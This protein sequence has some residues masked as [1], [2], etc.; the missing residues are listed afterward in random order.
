[1]LR[2]YSEVDNLRSIMVHSRSRYIP[3]W[4]SQSQLISPNRFNENQDR[5]NGSRKSQRIIN[6]VATRAL[7]TFVGGMMNGSTSRQRPWFRLTVTDPRKANLSASKKYFAQLET[8]FNA[9]FQVGNL[10]KI[11]PISY[12]D[13][14]VFS[15]SAYA[16]LPHARYG[17]YFYPFAMGSYGIA[18]D[19]EGN[20]NTFFRDFTMSVRQTVERYGNLKP[21]GHI[22]WANIDPFIKEAWENAR[23]LDEVTLTNVIMPNAAPKEQSIFSYDKKFQSYTYVK[24]YGSNLPNQSPIGQ[25]QI[26]SSTSNNKSFDGRFLSVKGYDYFPVIA[27]RWELGAEDDWGIDGPGEIAYGDIATLQEME[28]DRLSGAQKLVRPPMVGPTSLRRHQASIL[29][30]GI[31]FVDENNESGKF[32][33]AFEVDPRLAELIATGDK[34]ERAIQSAFYEDLFLM[35]ANER[36]ISHVSA[37]EI[38]ER[39]AEKLSAIGP[40]LGQLDQDQNGNLIDNAFYILGSQGKLPRPPK[41]LEGEELR[42]E[43]ISILAQASKNSMAVASERYINFVQGAANA[44]QD[45]ALLKMVRGDRLIR[46]YADY[47]GIDPNHL[48]DEIEFDQIR[49]LE[50]IRQQQL[51]Q[52]QQMAQAAKSAKDLAGATMGESNLLERMA[53]EGAA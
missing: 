38:E 27:N 20:V 26:N 28:K 46:D 10:Y 29:A 35:L 25:R 4:R 6:N 33:P 11:L 39:A 49:Q 36:A 8:V 37:R 51:V 14:G 17:F 34:Y 41:E 31:T 24:S 32:R 44:L 52:Q 22:E 18:N 30:G 13:I 50:N 12:K 42:P 16:M 3:T 7:R 48:P 21:T 40:V 5:N 2:S 53:S 9:Y 23:Y 1:M 45:P 19:S 15:N 47:V 43:Y